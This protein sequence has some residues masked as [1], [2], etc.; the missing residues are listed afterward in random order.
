MD[1]TQLLLSATSGDTSVISQAQQAL[2][3]LE[4]ANYPQYLLSLVTEMGTEGRPQQARQLAGLLLK[5]TLVAKDEVTRKE[6]SARWVQLEGGVRGRIKAML[7]EIL[8]SSIKEIRSTAAL[9]VASIA[10][11]EIPRA[12]WPELIAR[13]VAAILSASPDPFLKQA[14]FE[15][16]GYVCEEEDNHPHLRQHSNMILTAIA[17][18]M[19]ADEKNAD[20][21]YAATMALAN[22]LHF[23]EQNMEQQ[24]ER[25]EIM[26]MVFSAALSD[27]ERVR[28]ASLQCLVTIA[29]AYYRYL[30]PYMQH[31]YNLTSNA[32]VHE[33]EDVQ[34]QAI[35]FWSTLSDCEIL[36]KEEALDDPQTDPTLNKKYVTAAIPELVPRLLDSLTKQSEDVEDETWNPAMA[37]ATCLSLIAE[38]AGDPVVPVVLPFITQNIASPNWRHKEAATIAFGCILDGPKD[39]IIRELVSKA[40][41]VILENMRDSNDLVKDTASWTIG[42]ICHLHP[43]TTTEL[44]DKLIAAFISGLSD[45]PSVSGNVCWAIHNLANALPQDDDASNALSKYFLDL[46]QALLMVTRRQDVDKHNL[47]ASAYEAINALI[48]TAARESSAIIQQLIPVLLQQLDQT[49]HNTALSGSEREKQ[50]EVQAL[51]CGACQTIIQKL[52]A[53]VILTHADAFMVL[54]IRVLGSKNATVHEEALMAI[55][56]LANRVHEQFDKYIAAIT[57]FLFTGLR[58]EKEYKVCTVAVGLVGD[59]SRAIDAK[60]IPLSDE[61]MKVLLQHLSSS[62][63]ER[64]VKPHIISCLGDIA[65]AVGAYFVRY[66][67]FV[68]RI[69]IPASK[70]L[71][72]KAEANYD[73]L[74]YL[75][76]LRESILESWTGILQGLSADNEQDQFLAP[77]PVNPSDPASS[78]P[79]FPLEHVLLF[80]DLIAQDEHSGEAVVRAACGLI[81]DLCST[82]GA[83]LKPM[84]ARKSVE[85]LIQ[86]GLQSDTDHTTKQQAKW[87]KEEVLKLAR[88]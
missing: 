72:P 57:P 87:A 77:I 33:K 41:P 80:F 60:F 54:F 22:S 7:F 31:I 16:L 83:K 27:M 42:R 73:D 52:D 8:A 17:R 39:V 25:N 10:S 5:N 51:L 18:G 67:P 3:Q 44:L 15:C 71:F 65:L 49:M 35:E 26:N 79:I 55:G 34:L 81:G 19:H 48:Q 70:L 69:L 59:I 74:D 86:A 56:A 66:L 61:V 11:I 53:P 75:D 76:A 13:L 68:F 85:D 23:V 63:I 12:E 20:I 9:A 64:S 45:V 78:P 88:G 24:K 37:A 2:V 38:A 4:Q 47:L 84:I 32:I 21:R 62:S 36:F 82:C 28:V 14:S 1:L 58:N 43:E 50:N 40:F 30:E 46:M 29:S 6:L